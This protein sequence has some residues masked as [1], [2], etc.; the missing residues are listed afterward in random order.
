MASCKDAGDIEN[1]RTENW[2]R[3]NRDRLVEAVK[4]LLNP[5]FEHKGGIYEHTI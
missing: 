3:E 2:W 4:E 5:C 1:A